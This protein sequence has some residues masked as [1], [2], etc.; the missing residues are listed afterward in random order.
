LYYWHTDAQG[1]YSKSK[2]ET[3]VHGH[4]RGWVKTDAQG[5]YAIY[6]VKPSPYPNDRLPAH[7]HF[8]VKEPH[9]N[10]YYT[11]DVVFENEAFVDAKYRKSVTNRCGN[12]II[13]TSLKEGVLYGKRDFY[14]GL[15]IP[16]YPKKSTYQWE[17]LSNGAAF[18]KS[19]NFQLHS[20]RDTL[21]S[22]H[23][24]GGYWS[25]D[26]QEW[27]KTSL[28]NIVKNQAFLDY[29]YFKDALWGLG[30]FE[31]NIETFRQTTAIYR[32]TDM[33]TWQKMA[34]VSN[35]PCRFFY[36]PF[37]FQGK[38]WLI[39]GSDKDNQYADIW[40]SDDGVHWQQ[41]AQNQPFGLRENTQVVQLNNRLFML[42]NDVW[43]ST[44]GMKW[45][46]ETSE[47]QKNTTLFGYQAVVFDNKIWLLGC[48][49]N[50][51]FTSNVLYS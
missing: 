38:I 44:D 48:N 20:I 43:S 49:R 33:K 32:T 51:Q 34:E 19:Y 46:L 2:T 45:Q 14:L 12:G 28:S 18:A 16:N 36:H 7:I 1:Y 29:V 4:L 13:K 37:V 35:L 40:R 17:N 5:R 50:L 31:G 10:E 41:V 25:L 39:G 15:N 27:H 30:T 23:H 3:T 22:I 21:W 26:G 11:D 8:S 24:D 42:N 6:T 47:I 9:L